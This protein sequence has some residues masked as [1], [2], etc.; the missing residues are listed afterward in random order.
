MAEAA[1]VQPTFDASPTQHPPAAP[2]Q[3]PAPT[4]V[5]ALPQRVFVSDSAAGD[6]AQAA[7][8]AL[9]RLAELLAHRGAEGPFAI[10]LIG[11]PGSG[12]SRALSQLIADAAA[13]SR[14]AEGKS[15]PYLGSLLTV[16]L[17]AARLGADVRA[18]IAE[19]LHAEL[20]RTAP[21]IAAEAAE[22]ANH[23]AVDPHA[24]LQSLTESLDASRRR[25]DAERRARDEAESRR[26][27][28]VETILY[29]SGGSRV[30]AYARANRA[31]IEASLTSFGFT[32]GDPLAT[33][34]GLVHTL[35]DS[36]GPA[37]RIAASAKS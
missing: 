26:A 17:D 10:G 5:P 2:P 3:R 31:P 25:L 18:A 22:E 11:G 6:D 14:A 32:K 34:K 30:D 19:H 37:A 35:A 23:S 16:K 12:K 21:E 20:S 36:A 8:P 28:L 29:E 1:R 4:P 33:Y 27:R 13:L 9:Q 15:S 7:S 24:Q